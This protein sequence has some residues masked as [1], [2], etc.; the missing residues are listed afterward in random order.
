[1]TKEEALARWRSPSAKE[2]PVDM[3][4]GAIE[5]VTIHCSDGT[6]RM[7]ISEGPPPATSVATPSA[8]VDE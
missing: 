7:P 3:S 2:K 4:D 1:M 8:E 5:S 6:I